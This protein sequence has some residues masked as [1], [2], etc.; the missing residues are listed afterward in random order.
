MRGCQDHYD[1]VDLECAECARFLP[2]PPLTVAALRSRIAYIEHDLRETL[3][4]VLHHFG[5][6]GAKVVTDHVM[7]SRTTKANT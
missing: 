3:R 1:K 5:P 7:A 6:E 2:E 4:A